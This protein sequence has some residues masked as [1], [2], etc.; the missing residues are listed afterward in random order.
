MRKQGI[1]AKDDATLYAITIPHLVDWKQR[2]KTI[3]PL[4]I[5]GL[6]F[7]DKTDQRKLCQAIN[8]RVVQMASENPTILD[9]E[10]IVNV[11]LVQL[12][13]EG[14]VTFQAKILTFLYIALQAHIELQ[15]TA[16]IPL[17][18]LVAVLHHLPERYLRHRVKPGIC[19]EEEEIV[20]FEFP[21]SLVED[22][23]IQRA[24]ATKTI[25]FSQNLLVVVIFC[26]GEIPPN[27]LPN[28]IF[29]SSM[30]IDLV[31]LLT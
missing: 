24:S 12:L 28:P 21:I 4:E 7:S 9:N 5:L 25:Q 16:T 8:N 26:Y 3:L 11:Y 2:V 17:K 14:V 6:A 1:Q 29:Y 27:L 23:T 30:S 22:A 13:F 18:F 20:L 31:V 19:Q 10:V 15:L